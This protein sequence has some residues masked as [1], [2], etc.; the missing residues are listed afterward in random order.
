MSIPLELFLHV[1]RDLTEFQREVISLVFNEEDDV[2]QITL[3]INKINRHVALLTDNGW[4]PTKSTG[5]MV[6]R[7]EHYDRFPIE[8]TFFIMENS[9]DWLRGNFLKYVCRFPYKNG[10]EDLRKAMRNLAMYVRWHDM[11]PSWSR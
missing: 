5:D 11:D 9:I 4:S 7:P 3:A 8:P 10:I 1:N 6:N 2:G